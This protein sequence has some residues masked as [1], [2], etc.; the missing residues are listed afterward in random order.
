MQSHLEQL[1]AV[2]LP[3]SRWLSTL[4]PL[5]AISLRRRTE[6]EMKLYVD[7]DVAA[8]LPLGSSVGSNNFSSSTLLHN[9]LGR[10]KLTGVL[11]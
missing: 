10:G 8:Q 9:G 4:M 11:Q 1:H 6:E 3:L 5:I 2:W 7:D